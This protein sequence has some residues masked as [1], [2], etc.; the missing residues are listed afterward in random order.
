MYI[1][2]SVSLFFVSM[3]LCC[4][5]MCFRGIICG[6]GGK[7]GMVN[8]QAYLSL[9]SELDRTI[10]LYEKLKALHEGDGKYIAELDEINKV[11]LSLVWIQLEWCF[12]H[13]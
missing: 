5:W 13:R 1:G 9:R 7:D 12:H 6:R 2:V 10:T 4:W 3:T 11:R 8:M